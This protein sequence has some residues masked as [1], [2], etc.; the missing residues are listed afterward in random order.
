MVLKTHPKDVAVHS[1]IASLYEKK[2]NFKEAEN[3]FRLCVTFEPKNLDCR[4]AL[5]LLYLSQRRKL[6]AEKELQNIL[7]INP[8]HLEAKKLLENKLNIATIGKP[9]PP[10]TPLKPSRTK[11]NSIDLKSSGDWNL[12]NSQLSNGEPSTPATGS[13]ATSPIPNLEQLKQDQISS[14]PQPV[15]QTSIQQTG[16]EKRETENAK[17]VSPSHER[18]TVFSSDFWLGFGV[19][20]ALALVLAVATRKN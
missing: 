4:L 5:A 20:S 7:L 2:G 11:H 1:Y 15:S 12:R 14:V 9:P 16:T 13:P 3:H 17:A 10:P 18:S 8:N 6:D 19:A